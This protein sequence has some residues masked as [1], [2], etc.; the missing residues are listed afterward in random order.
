[1][2]IFELHKK[3]PRLFQIAKYGVVGVIAT[4]AHNLFYHYMMEA[5]YMTSTLNNLLAYSVSLQ[6]SYWGHRLVTFSNPKNLNTK[7]SIHKFLIS[8]GTA[9]L[10]SSIVSYV[11][12]DTLKYSHYY[13]IAFNVTCMPLF[14]FMILKLWVFRAAEASS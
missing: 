11:L 3:W 8:A 12:I 7:A 9:I 10:I 13:L 1:M 6:V 5:Q 14:S 4:I 2:S